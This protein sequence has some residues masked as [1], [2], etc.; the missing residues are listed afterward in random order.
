MILILMSV[1]ICW[2]WF[3]TSNSMVE[4]P[5]Y[6]ISLMNLLGGYTCSSR[7]ARM[8]RLEKRRKRMERG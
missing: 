2:D 5:R 6:E 3:P 4:T 8:T 1:D 7:S